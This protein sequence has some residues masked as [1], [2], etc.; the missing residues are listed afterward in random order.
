[1]NSTTHVSIFFLFLLLV[2]FIWHQSLHLRVVGVICCTAMDNRIDDLERK[3]DEVMRQ[4][5]RK[6][7]ARVRGCSLPQGG[8]HPV[9]VEDRWDEGTEGG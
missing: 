2:S 7:H 3:L 4:L 8:P 9:D 6:H 5:R 1:M